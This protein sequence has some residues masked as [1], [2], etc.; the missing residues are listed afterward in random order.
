MLRSVF[1]ALLLST[2]GCGVLLPYVDDAG[3][4]DD[5]LTRSMPK[6]E[7]LQ[8]L[9][10][11]SRTLQKNDHLTIWEYRLFPKHEWY[12]Y[13]LHCPWHPFCYFPAEPR[14]PYHVALWDERLCLWGTP[15][16]IQMVAPRLCGMEGGPGYAELRNPT[17]VSVIPV[18]MP[19]PVAAPVQRLA[20]IPVG[21]EDHREF[22]SWLDHT[23]NFVRRRQPHLTI[24]QRSN[25]QFI[26]GE[27]NLQYSGR[28]DDKTIVAI[29]RFVG[30]DNLLI[31][32][33]DTMESRG[34]MSASVELALIEVETG[35]TLF[36]QHT[37]A[38]A[39]G[40][41]VRASTRDLAVEVSASY[42]L[43]ALAAA[44]GENHLGIVPDYSWTGTGVRLLGLLHGGPAYASGMKE[45]DVITAADGTT[46][47]S[48]N[49]LTSLPS[50]LVLQRAGT[51]VVVDL[52]PETW[53]S[54]PK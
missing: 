34:T 53:R 16:L 39:T 37:T 50:S 31:Y 52:G 54:L 44:L 28:T 6:A 15:G 30:A 11:P 43:A 42:G 38:L 36:Q 24:V 29:G 49:E 21:P 8:Q 9:G 51:Q 5:R 35:V 12:G 14:E 25:L 46:L 19:R 26:Q 13:L 40:S 48:W 7:V 20:V 10:K 41:S 22:L 33:V 1:L 32:R 18:F 45:G 17:D 4:L 2:A 27:V 47:R 23:L 3:K